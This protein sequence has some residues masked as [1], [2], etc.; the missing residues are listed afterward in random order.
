MGAKNAEA[1]E[2][3]VDLAAVVTVDQLPAAAAAGLVALVAVAALVVEVHTGIVVGRALTVAAM[4]DDHE[5]VSSRIVI[6]VIIMAAVAMTTVVMVMQLVAKMTATSGKKRKKNRD[7][8]KQLHCLRLTRK[9]RRLRQQ[10]QL[11]RRRKLKV[12]RLM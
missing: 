4:A 8:M 1:V 2:S 7:Q 12:H 10:H 3:G 11:I 5:N 9:P 6:A